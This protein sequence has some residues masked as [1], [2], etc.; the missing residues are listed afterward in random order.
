MVSG[1]FTESRGNPGVE[2]C[3]GRL[4]VAF[5]A[6]I[7]IA[8]ASGSLF[9]LSTWFRDLAAFTA[10]ACFSLTVCCRRD[11]GRVP[12]FI[13]APG[14]CLAV[15]L[16]LL[17]Q[18]PAPRLALLA[19]VFTSEFWVERSLGGKRRGRGAEVLLL[20][21]VCLAYAGWLAAYARSPR[22]WF[23][24]RSLLAFPTFGS[25]TLSDVLVYESV[26]IIAVAT[27]VV[28]AGG[29]VRPSRRCAMR[30][31]AGC[32]ILT[33]LV[34]L[35]P[36]GSR[37][38]DARAAGAAIPSRPLNI[39]L[40]SEGLLDWQ[41]PSPERLGI[42]RSGM[43]G[44]FRKSLERYALSRRGAVLEVD[45]LAQE[46]LAETRLLVFIN[47]TRCLAPAEQDIL[48][49][50]VASGGGLLVLGD[51]TDIGGSRA[52]LNGAL[53]FTSIEF[54]FDSAISLRE[55]WTGCLEIRRH[56]VTAGVEDEVDTQMGTG[57]SLEITRPAF[58][59]I[60]GRYAFG[61][62]GNYENDGR[63]AH[64][65]NCRHD[66]GEALGDIV[67]VAGEEVGS[68]RVLVFGDTSPFQN[69]A[70]F[71]SQHLVA[72]SLRWVSGEDDYRAGAAAPDIRPFD[73][74]AVID[75][76]LNPEASRDLFT[77]TSLGG[78]AN[79]LCRAGFT[80]V[81]SYGDDVEG[82]ALAFLIAPTRRVTA[83][84]MRCL[85]EYMRSG[86]SLVVAKG[87]AAPEP[88]AG[89]F[90]EV[91]FKLEYIPLGG[92]GTSP[93]LRHRDAWGLI[94]DGPPDTVVHAVAFGHPTVVTRPVGSGTF[95]LIADGGLL[96]DAS[97]E[98]ETEAIPENVRFLAAL[99]DDLRKERRDLGPTDRVLAGYHSH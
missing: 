75:F 79:C 3:A 74:I 55:G 22:L 70:R 45:S 93:R 10:L 1:N 20:G 34:V 80:P 95:T 62:L 57:A 15:Y 78:L 73:D 38:L 97:L 94:Y 26:A 98:G 2:S 91:G 44:L 36:A 48:A 39:A 66:K 6:V 92:G 37:L 64:M 72:N 9:P 27:L 67:L 59:V 41:V 76:G 46:T 29:R 11:T 90:A 49:G 16:C 43:F 42:I 18:A 32:A 40:Y 63:G 17:V 71:L 30:L 4:A 52:P 33:L 84:R 35:V 86:G 28:L 23:L 53:A 8:L 13:L 51:H 58:P 85:M 69:G 89:L 14:L 31:T 25:A 19:W 68:G 65:G 24:K 5:F 99:I 81:P 87:Y 47:P 60:T 12:G 96:L 50:F 77:D 82:A 21:V 88:C 61:D 56:R 54:N 83:A 7:G